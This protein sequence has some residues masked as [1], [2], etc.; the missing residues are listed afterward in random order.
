MVVDN[1]RNYIFSKLFFPKVVMIDKPGIIYNYVDR[2]FGSARA[3]KRIVFFFEDVFVNLQ[4]ETTKQI[5]KK[6]SDDLFYKIGKEQALRY[7][8]LAKSSNI[9]S[10]L[11][12]NIINYLFTTLQT[13]G[14]MLASEVI[15]DNNKKSL[16]LKGKD[17]LFCRKGGN[18]Q[19]FCGFISGIM[20]FLYKQTMEAESKCGK[21]PSECKVICNPKIK[22][23]ILIKYNKLKPLENYNTLNFPLNMVVPKNMHSYSKLIKFKKIKLN[24]NGEQ[25][26][27]D[28]TIFPTEIGVAGIITQNFFDI[29]QE[30][31]LEKGLSEGSYKLAKDILKSKNNKKDKLEL[32]K[33]ILCALGWGI[34]YFDF[35]KDNVSC[36]FLYPPISKYGFCYQAFTLKGYLN[37]IFNKKLVIKDISNKDKYIIISYTTY[38]K[39]P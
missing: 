15:L 8:F 17:N 28:K 6:K 2:K 31:L 18:N 39:F 26:F 36:K 38:K 29:K 10:Y 25:T 23:K 12:P 5:G 22:K 14:F 4:L 33:K 7:M 24:K 37:Y 19:I 3:K 16:V 1:I 27:L 21:C 13:S 11:I 20:S 34:P 30:N 35:Y 32:L 9:P